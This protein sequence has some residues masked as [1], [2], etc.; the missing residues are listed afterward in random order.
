[1]AELGF[2]LEGWDR[3]TFTLLLVQ[4]GRREKFIEIGSVAIV[5]H[6]KKNGCSINLQIFYL[7][8]ISHL[9]NNL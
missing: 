7:H 4:K 8:D 1:V 9:K 6:E 2:F 5:S 3:G